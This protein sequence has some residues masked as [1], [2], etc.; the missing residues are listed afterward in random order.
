MI[1]ELNRYNTE[2]DRSAAF[3]ACRTSASV[4]PFKAKKNYPEMISRGID[5]LCFGLC[6]G[7]ITLSICLLGLLCV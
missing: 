5:R 7:A 1:Y 2:D 6:F 3:L 4:I